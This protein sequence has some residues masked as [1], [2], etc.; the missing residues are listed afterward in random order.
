MSAESGADSA[1]PNLNLTPEEKRVY[2][3]L[4]KQADPENLRVVTGDAAVTFFDKTRLDSRVLGEIWQIADKENRG[5]LTPV[6]FG[7]VLRL[8]AHAQ[9]GREPRAELAVQPAPLPRFEGMQMPA[10]AAAAASP[11]LQAQGT[12]G[13]IRI[14]PLTPDKVAQYTSL[15]ERQAIQGNMLAGD[16]ARQIFDKSGMPNETLGRI[17]ALADTEQRGALVLAEFIIAMH[18]LTSMKTGALRALP[19]VLPAGLY[20]AATQRGSISG[21]RQSPTNTGLSA[22]PRQ[23]SGTAQPRTGSPLGRTS[24]SAGPAGGDW[25]ITAADKERFD[26]IYATLDKTKKGYITG[27]EAVPFFSQSNLS[28]EVLAQIWDL[29]DF[30]SQGTLNPDAF[31]VAMYLIRQQRSGRSAPLPS[32]LPAN[33]I[34]PSMRSQPRP[35]AA[36]SAFDPPPMTQA[37]PPQPKS[38]L[39]DLFGLDSGASSPTPA[40]PLQTTMSTGGSNANDPFAG[41]SAVLSPS[42]PVRGAAPTS[43]FKPF[44]PSSSFGRGLTV[45]S[46]G[47][48]PAVRQS[49]DL[50]DDHD[51][52]ASKKISGETTELANLSNQIG[53]L[54]KEMQDVQSKR[55]TIQNDLNQSNSQKQ[56]FE[57]RLA[58]LR[59]LYE[60]E[61]EDT[62][63]LEEQLRKSRSETQKLQGECMTLESQ[64]R[65]TQAQ[66][67]QFLNAYQ[68]DQQENTKLRERIR[69]VNGEIAQLKPQIEKLKS[70][71]RQQKGLVAINKKQLATTEGERDK[72]KTE[73]EDL[74]KANEEASRHIDSSS[75]VSTSAHVASPAL[76]SSSGNNPFFKRTASTDIMGAFPPPASRGVPDK[77]FDDVFGPSFPAVP[78]STSPPPAAMAFKQ[79]NTGN[80]VASGASYNTASSTPQISRQGTLAAEP[81]AP[82]ESRQI[83]SSFLPFPDHSE[84]LSSSRQVSPPA[85]RAEGSVAGSAT[86]PLA[87]EAASAGITKAASTSDDGDKTEPASPAPTSGDAKETIAGEVAPQ[88]TTSPG[89]VEFGN[90][91]QAKAKADFDNAFAAFTSSSKSQNSTAADGAKTQSAFDSE[92]PPIS[93]LERDDDSDSDSERGGFDDDFTPTSPKHKADGKTTGSE[94][95]PE[96]KQSDAAA[97]KEPTDGLSRG[98]E[99]PSSPATITTANV[100]A[101]KPS[102]SANDI[103]DDIFGSSSLP[104]APPS[105]APKNTVAKGAF[106]DLDDD[107]EGLEDAK[108][109][110]AD[111]DF[112]NISRD[113][114]NPVFDSS[115][116]PSQTKSESTAFGNES[117][118]DFVPSHSATG[119]AAGVGGAQQKPAENHDWD[120]IFAGLDSPNTVTPPGISNTGA[121]GNDDKKDSR[122]SAPGRALTDQGEHDDPILKNLTGMGYSRADAVAALEKYDY[123]LERA[124]NYLA[125]Q[126]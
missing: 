35:A 110:S 106:D 62:R 10:A 121:T 117:S 26:Q 94:P 76:S 69:V 21:P 122:P 23:L 2:G 50:L 125:S 54:S 6:G 113:D 47:D 18:L 66:H 92:F 4:F 85:S 70:D 33:L 37:P 24:Q 96:A 48:K 44:V 65:D 101:A 87:G 123:N 39:E 120:A 88:T 7:I 124:A 17:W 40:A 77:S 22:I 29:A 52:E 14:P 72:L 116:P 80:S 43:T 19:T 111:D 3:D 115:P 98:S 102:P 9:A 25:A 13:G 63:A 64:Y 36:S 58:Q 99:Q 75:P 90:T 45:Q 41:G 118:F 60:K 61:A 55:T 84:S 71:A 30:N 81:P 86:T 67:Q 74:T 5:F 126:S 119:P 1:A 42:S 12:G 78:T 109:G 100:L 8:I 56:N 28:E 93:E 20:E 16:Q 46:T 27:D 97:A 73:A 68:A 31:A 59:A 11:A 38:A 114:F 112:A 15:F 32:S 51:P 95:A 89:A 83:S 91:D 79:Q 53:S 105:S 82:P 103:A 57:Q 107:F 34:P 49:D 104:P 108:E